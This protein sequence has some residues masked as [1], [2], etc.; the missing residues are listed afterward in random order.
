MDSMIK[1]AEV[2]PVDPA[3]LPYGGLGEQD[4]QTGEDG[5]SIG[6]NLAES[7][8][9]KEPSGIGNEADEHTVDVSDG[10]TESHGIDDKYIT[11]AD[12][13]P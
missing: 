4:E 10:N 8:A 9:L 2:V 3:L 1:S 13:K 5:C 12:R 6:D 11:G 7:D